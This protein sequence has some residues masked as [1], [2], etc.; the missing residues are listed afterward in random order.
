[1]RGTAHQRWAEWCNVVRICAI[2]YH[3]WVRYRLGVGLL[4][5]GS[6][7]RIMAAIGC[8]VLIVTNAAGGVNPSYNVGDVAM[9]DDHIFFPGVAGQH[10]LVRTAPQLLPLPPPLHFYTTHTLIALCGVSCV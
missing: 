4:Q 8:R 1:M 5:V 10:P 7:S 2:R 6:L 3:L 9:I